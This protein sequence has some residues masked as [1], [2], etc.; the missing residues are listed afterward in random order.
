MISTTLETHLSNI[1]RMKRILRA[2][3]ES[4]AL[5]IQDTVIYLRA[6]RSRHVV[7]TPILLLLRTANFTKFKVQVPILRTIIPTIFIIKAHLIH[8]ISSVVMAGIGVLVSLC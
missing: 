8:P 7:L 5:S 2:E 4:T 6:T 1:N 3:S